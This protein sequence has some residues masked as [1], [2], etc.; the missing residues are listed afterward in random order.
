[1]GV[2]L[3][4]QRVMNDCQ[5]R[6]LKVTQYWLQKDYH[7]VMIEYLITWFLFDV[8]VY[9]MIMAAGLTYERLAFSKSS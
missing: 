9:L 5:R 7:T 4:T 3:V 1:M 8:I 6:L 2:A